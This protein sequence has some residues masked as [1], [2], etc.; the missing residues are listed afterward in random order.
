MLNRLT[1]FLFLFALLIGC[2][3]EKSNQS[4][5]GSKNEATLFNMRFLFTDAEKRI[6]FPLWFNDSLIRNNNIQKITRKI[7]FVDPGDSLDLKTLAMDIPREQRVYSF[8]K[9][10]NLKELL[11]SY[12][13]DDR[14]IGKVH[15]EYKTIKDENGYAKVLLK[16]RSTEGSEISEQ[17]LDFPFELYRKV[18]KADKFL[19]YENTETGDYLFFITDKKYYGPW[20]IDTILR[21]TPKDIIVL[22]KPA[23]QE[24][25]YKVQNR[26]NESDVSKRSYEAKSDR[27]KDLVKQDYPFETKRT[28]VYDKQGKCNAY[29]D[30]TFSGSSY[31]TRVLSEIVFDKKNRPI[32]VIHRK[33]NR[34]NIVGRIS[35]ELFTYE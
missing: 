14:E 8:V 2:S 19:A 6:S 18:K 26:V 7:Y 35:I 12:Y 20:S 32:Y 5:R 16:D 30:S 21:P 27:I 33:E 29:I 3:R 28:F 10:G 22:G 25:E 17:P 13:Y 15:F 23:R 31:L 9:D 11:V 24:K 1:L 34:E 4:N